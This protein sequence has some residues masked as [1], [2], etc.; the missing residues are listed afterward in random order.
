MNG[1]PRSLRIE[2]L[3]SAHEIRL[4]QHI[5]SVRFELRTIQVILQLCFELFDHCV[6]YVGWTLINESAILVSK[7]FWIIS[8]A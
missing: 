3:T 7:K 1:G 8:L 2:K 5:P 6:N 4:H